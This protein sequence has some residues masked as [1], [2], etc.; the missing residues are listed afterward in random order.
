MKC[1]LK[2][3]CRL[4]TWNKAELFRRWPQCMIPTADKKESP[5][6]IF[7]GMLGNV[8]NK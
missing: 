8:K 1:M 7:T 4:L 2:Y 5:D 3:Y 6:Y